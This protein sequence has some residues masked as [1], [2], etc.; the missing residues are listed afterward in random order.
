[1]FFF[2]LLGIFSDSLNMYLKS[3]MLYE[4]PYS[5]TAGNGFL[6]TRGG[7]SAE[8]VSVYS[9]SN[10]YHPELISVLDNFT[11]SYKSIKAPSCFK[12]YKKR[13]IYWIGVLNVEDP[14]NMF[15]E[16]SFTTNFIEY[17][18]ISDTLL[19]IYPEHPYALGLYS[20][21]DP[22]SPVLLSSYTP[23]SLSVSNF[24]VV[25]TLCYFTDGMNFEVVDVKDPT[26][27]VFLYYCDSIISS[28]SVYQR[29]LIGEGNYLYLILSFN[30]NGYYYDSLY[31]L[32]IENPESI[33]IS[34]KYEFPYIYYQEYTEYGNNYPAVIN[35]TLL[36]CIQKPLYVDSSY[37]YTFSLSHTG[38]ILPVGS[39][40]KQILIPQTDAFRDMIFV[41]SL[42]YVTG[43]FSGIHVFSSRLE[44]V[45]WGCYSGVLNRVIQKDNLIYTVSFG[46][47]MRIFKYISDS[48]VEITKGGQPI[49]GMDISIIDTF[50]YIADYENGIDIYSIA[51][52]SEPRLIGQFSNFPDT[53]HSTDITV[54]SNYIYI[55]RSYW[56]YPWKPNFRAYPSR[57]YILDRND[58]SIISS[59]DSVRGTITLNKPFAYIG[60]DVVDLTDVSDPWVITCLD[61][62]D[63]ACYNC[64][65]KSTLYLS[66]GNLY[67]VS[68]PTLP[69]LIGSVTPGVGE[70]RGDSIYIAY[71]DW[72]WLPNVNN[73]YVYDIS[74]PDSSYIVAYG[75]IRS[76]G[77]SYA[78][79]FTNKDIL[80]GGIPFLYHIGLGAQGI[81]ENKVRKK[82]GA[83]ITFR[84]RMLYCK[85]KG[86]FSLNVYDVAGR[87][88]K[89]GV[90]IN[91]GE[92]RMD[93]LPSGIYFAHISRF[94]LTKK[95][96]LIK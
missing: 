32:N 79:P 86:K 13:L 52:P 9:Y 90:F 66:N 58:L 56:A 4:C 95:I 65:K 8:F 20:L 7:D 24:F 26:N 91:R 12:Y 3:P 30:E 61:S 73:I 63:D 77:I 76:S 78:Y 35:D 71:T 96:I 27:P 38:Q 81:K 23:E 5:I 72:S 31:V 51:N 17:M 6:Y 40:G 48:L 88:V 10:P 37:I 47:G 34:N 94:H 62:S 19:Y 87:K 44:E 85:A 33:F 18:Q 50:G 89:A 49:A 64:L 75:Y 21:S 57:F 53:L 22:S 70:I 46:S 55:T 29:N 67:S 80:A 93:N 11:S 39:Y 28:P 36:Y 16:D 83:A 82:V 54:D 60:A 84:N 59:L 15:Y 41:D 92:M 25:D 43:W 42:L 74:R 2:L 69:R 1:M 14:Y 45:G 68:N